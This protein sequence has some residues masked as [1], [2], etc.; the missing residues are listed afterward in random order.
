LLS[1]PLITLTTDFG[2]ASPYVAAMKGAILGINADARLVDLTHK[3]PPQDVRQAAYYLLNSI[4][5]FPSSCIH[6]V[7]VDPGV[8]TGRSILLA[9][10]GR[11]Q[12]LA[13]DNGCWTPLCRACGQP[14][15]VI[16]LTESRYWRQAVSPTF[17]GRDIFAPV[18]GWLSRGLEPTLLGP[19][20]TDWLRLDLP[21]PRKDADGWHGEVLFIDDFGN[22]I[23]NIPGEAL[24]QCKDRS[25]QVSVG[26]HQLTRRVR[27]Y[28]D[29]PRGSEVLLIS[30]S[31]LLEIAVV[32]GNAAARLGCQVGS[33][34]KMEEL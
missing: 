34:V 13:P 12:L 32:D 7:V 30:S 20:T 23:T 26:D 3:I 5:F 33:P 28:A 11:H 24:R 19:E 22:L 6:V 29:A 14:E 18:A 17:H 27:A 1:F 10:W 25:V 16:R 21:S 15:R 9:D 8:G 2:E 31:D 4:P